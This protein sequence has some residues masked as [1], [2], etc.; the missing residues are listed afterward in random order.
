[1]CGWNVRSV[2]KWESRHPIWPISSLDEI[3]VWR[4]LEWVLTIYSPSWSNKLPRPQQPQQY[5]RSKTV[6]M[7]EFSN[8][9]MNLSPTELRLA[10]LTVWGYPS[11]HLSYTFQLLSWSLLQMWQLY[12][13]C[14][15]FPWCRSEMC[16]LEFWAHQRWSGPSLPMLSVRQRC[17]RFPGDMSVLH[18]V[19][20]LA[21]GLSLWNSSSVRTQE[22]AT[23]HTHFNERVLA[24]QKSR[25]L[26]S[27]FICRRKLASSLTNA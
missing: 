21:R 5:L 23:V 27:G 16:M 9:K 25:I 18:G 1:M 7:G 11:A 2:L 19:W 14:L 22:V 10:L 4:L 6:S 17:I 20:G 13:M 12:Q 8:R 15:L 26:Q 3:P 24:L